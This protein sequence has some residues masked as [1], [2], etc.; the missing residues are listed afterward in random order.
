MSLSNVSFVVGL[1]VCK[2]SSWENSFF[3]FMEFSEL[4]IN[5]WIVFDKCVLSD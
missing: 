3:K 1:M 5:I 4:K 2:L